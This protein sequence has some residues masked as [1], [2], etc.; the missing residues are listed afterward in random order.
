[1]D[2]YETI[3]ENILYI[4]GA[5]ALLLVLRHII[6][7]II[8]ELEKRRGNRIIRNLWIQFLRSNEFINKGILQLNIIKYREGLWYFFSAI[9]GIF[10]G[11]FIISF[12]FIFL[13]IYLGDRWRSMSYSGFILFLPLL[14]YIFLGRYINELGK[15]VDEKLLS[16]SRLLSYFN[17][18]IRWFT[19]SIF[20]IYLVFFVSININLNN[21]GESNLV[22]ITSIFSLMLAIGLATLIQSI[23]NNKDLQYYLKPLI[24]QQYLEKF[25]KVYVTIGTIN[26]EGKICDLFHENLIVLCSNGEKQ[27]S[28]WDSITSIKLQDAGDQD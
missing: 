7:H 13:S 24:N 26:F 9:I 2:V 4:L 6:Q 17:E 1:M 12:L 11:F 23:I 3:T 28:R 18:G 15:R 8:S 16:K 5:P 10:L 14:L 27:A 25:P 21:I 20:L 19:S 22:T